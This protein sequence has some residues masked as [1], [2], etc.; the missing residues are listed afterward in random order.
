MLLRRP[1]TQFVEIAKI[2]HQNEELN[3]LTGFGSGKPGILAAEMAMDAL[4]DLPPSMMAFALWD[5]DEVPVG[6]TVLTD[7]DEKN[8]SASLHVTLPPANQGYGLGM[9]ALKDTLRKAFKAGL[10]RITF[11]PL[12]TNQ[13]AVEV[14]VKAG[15]KVE[16]RTRGS[17]WMDSGPKDQVQMRA[18][19]PEWEKKHG[20]SR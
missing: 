7:I 13:R 15:F 5:E 20:N 9:T 1:S 16:A 11:C 18:I 6:Y 14:A 12:V 10:W 4:V 19:K 17:V 8:R 3:K 2:W